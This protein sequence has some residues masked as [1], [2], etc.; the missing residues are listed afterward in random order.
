MLDFIDVGDN[1]SKIE[2]ELKGRGVRKY[3]IV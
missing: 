3:I 2:E 1:W